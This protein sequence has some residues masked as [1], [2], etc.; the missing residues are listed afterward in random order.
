MK[1]VPANGKLSRVP[2]QTDSLSVS[3]RSG[4]MRDDTR[5]HVLSESVALED[6]SIR[7]E[8]N[9]DTVVASP[10]PVSKRVRFAD[11]VP[12]RSLVDMCPADL[13][14]GNT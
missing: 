10:S 7:D 4:N 14:V 2:P 9:K 13:Q 6:T 11:S 3:V 8:T 1:V 12:G 5:K